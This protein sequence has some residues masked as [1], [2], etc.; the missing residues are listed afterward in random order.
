M[1][2]EETVEMLNKIYER[3]LSYR[4]SVVNIKLRRTDE[5]IT[6][7]QMSG[8]FEVID[9]ITVQINESA[10]VTNEAVHRSCTASFVSRLI[11]IFR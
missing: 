5:T 11:E 9:Q 8:L 2:E 3:A 6:E 4:T 10:R 1:R 7:I